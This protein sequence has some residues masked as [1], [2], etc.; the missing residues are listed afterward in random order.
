[1]INLRF[2]EGTAIKSH[3]LLESGLCLSLLN[4]LLTLRHKQ[5]FYK[6][7]SPGYG[8]FN[9]G[10]TGIQKDFLTPEFYL[11][12]FVFFVSFFYLIKNIVINPDNSNTAGQSLYFLVEDLCLSKTLY[13]RG[14]VSQL[15]VLTINNSPRN[16]HSS[17]K[18]WFCLGV[19]DICDLK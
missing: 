14:V 12:C 3:N 17:F 4:Y 13:S 15:A 1:M 10:S 2:G 6:G 19:G 16:S 5:I 7:L 11:N 8:Y 9:G 18:M